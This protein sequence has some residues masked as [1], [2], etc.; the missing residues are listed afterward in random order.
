M[1][2]NPKK[3]Q[4]SITARVPATFQKFA[5]FIFCKE[6]LLKWS[7]K[8]ALIKQSLLQFLKQVQDT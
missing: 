8:T 1:K 7:L 3:Q 2:Q 5:S 6:N 4:S